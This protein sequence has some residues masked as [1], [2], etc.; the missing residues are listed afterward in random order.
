MGPR[1][2]WLTMAGRTGELHTGHCVIRLSN[3]EILH[4][5]AK[6]LVTAVHFATSS[7]H[8]LDAYIASGEPLKVAGGF[9]FDGL[10]G[11][12]TDAVA[13]DPSNVMGISLP[14]TRRLFERAGLSIFQ[15]REANALTGP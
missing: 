14:L 15:L 7:M 11:W 3:N 2:Q 6:T 10:G 4:Q 5:T 1:H 13:G 8:V 9:T 12:F